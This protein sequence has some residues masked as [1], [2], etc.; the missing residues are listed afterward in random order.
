MK[1]LLSVALML[2]SYWVTAQTVTW[3]GA[4]D[5]TWSNSGNWSPATVPNPC[6]RIVI[7]S[8]GTNKYPSLVSNVFVD[9]LVLSGGNFKSNQYGVNFIYGGNGIQSNVYNTF[10]NGDSL[11]FFSRYFKAQN[12]NS[13]HSLRRS[14]S[15]CAPTFRFEINQGEKWSGDIG[16]PPNCGNCHNGLVK[17]RTEMY[18]Q[19]A[20]IPFNQD[21]W[22]SYSVYI[23]P[24]DNISYGGNPDFYCMLG[25]W[26][27]GD[28]VP[29]GGPSWGIELLGQGNLNLFTRGQ[30]NLTPPFSG[31]R[32]W[33]VDRANTTVTRGAWHHIVVRARHNKNAGQI[34]WWVDNDP[35]PVY[36]GTNIP[37]GNDHTVI[38]YWKFGIYRTSNAANLA[39]RYANV[40]ILVDSTNSNTVNPLTLKGRI[41][42]PL[43][44]D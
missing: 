10:P 36:S 9:S 3:T 8:V 32:P 23:E 5:T 40:E 16:T 27:P 43:S 39:V 19:G 18:Q 21:V 35:T 15:T 4:V 6:N 42:T 13:A 17:E 30:E 26:H 38:G 33:A 28:A 14:T 29:S 25:Q 2:V 24:G 44:L 22:V 31:G 34:E 7:P 20:S 1:H 12:P 37:I 41:A 11:Q